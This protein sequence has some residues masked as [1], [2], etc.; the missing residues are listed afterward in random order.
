MRGSHISSYQDNSSVVFF[1]DA[2]K[3]SGGLQSLPDWCV[4]E[5]HCNDALIATIDYSPL[6][7]FTSNIW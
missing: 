6:V 4:Q 1:T 2:S 5:N 3:W 7:C